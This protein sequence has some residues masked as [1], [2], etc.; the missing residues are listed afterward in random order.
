MSSPPDL[1]VSIVPVLE[2]FG[3]IHQNPVVHNM[4]PMEVAKN[5]NSVRRRGGAGRCC[6]KKLLVNMFIIEI[7]TSTNAV[8]N[9]DGR[10]E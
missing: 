6:G 8:K 4:F 9:L 5:K 2:Q 10:G 7:P 3:E 1:D